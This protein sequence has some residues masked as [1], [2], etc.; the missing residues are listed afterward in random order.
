MGMGLLIER[1]QY[2]VVDQSVY[3]KAPCNMDGARVL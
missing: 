2:T 1:G 3:E